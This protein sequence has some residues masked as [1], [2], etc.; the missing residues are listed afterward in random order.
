MLKY[1]LKSRLILLSIEDLVLLSRLTSDAPEISFNHRGECT[2]LTCQDKKIT[3]VVI[4]NNYIK[5]SQLFHEDVRCNYCLGASNKDS[6][7][8]HHISKFICYEARGY[9]RIVIKNNS[10][11]LD[12]Y[13]ITLKRDN[14]YSGTHTQTCGSRRCD[15]VQFSFMNNDHIVRI[16][17]N[18]HLMI[19]EYH[20]GEMIYDTIQRKV[21]REYYDEDNIMIPVRDI[22]SLRMQLKMA[23]NVILEDL[24]HPLLDI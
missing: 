7:W 11:F 23:I 3:S 17:W 2:T 20:S 12:N 10:Y 9:K 16:N 4:F 15:I 18:E 24:G 1:I 8:N 13:N 22:N 21:T 19:A 5:L 6:L 14:W